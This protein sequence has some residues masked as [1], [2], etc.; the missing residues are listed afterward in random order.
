MIVDGLFMTLLAVGLSVFSNCLNALGLTV[1]KIAHKKLLIV[2][3]NLP[4]I[5]QKYYVCY[6][7]WQCGFGL[8]IT[9]SIIQAAALGFGPQSL[10]SPLCSVTLIANTLLA[11][12]FLGETLTNLDI[13]STFIII[14]ACSSAVYFGPK[15]TSLWTL[16]DIKHRFEDSSFIIMAICVAIILAIDYII[17]YFIQRRN[18]ANGIT[19]AQIS[20]Q[21]GGT[22]LMLSY[23]FI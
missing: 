1:E 20:T 11:P 5:E 23:C 8:C 6:G 16:R 12:A 19:L 14:I 10:L 9:G 17:V 13:L 18:I 7:L 4:E 21:K 15:S 22:F 2:N 3:A